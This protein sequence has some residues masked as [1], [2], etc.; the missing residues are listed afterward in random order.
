[1]ID[2]IEFEHE[3]IK[4]TVHVAWAG[5]EYE[6]DYGGAHYFAHHLH[7][8]HAVDGAKEKIRQLKLLEPVEAG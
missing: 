7:S 5:W 1:M 3:G 6:F 2:P 4:V 8:F